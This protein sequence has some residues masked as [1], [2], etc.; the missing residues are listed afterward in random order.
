MNTDLSPHLVSAQCVLTCEELD[1]TLSFFTET[2][3]FRVDTI[4][5]ADHP[6]VAVVSGHGIRIRLERSQEPANARIRLLCRDRDALTARTGGQT[7]LT[8]PNGTRIELADAEPPVV[9]PKAEQSLVV[10]RYHDESAW[11]VGRAGMLYRD[12]IPD[13]LGGAFIASHIRIPNGGPVPDYVHFHKIHFQMIYSYRGWARL[14]YEDQGEPFLLKAGDCVLQPPQIRHR[15][16]EC[17]DGM[18]VV[19][20]GCPAEHETF[21][22]HEMTLP[23]ETLA[24]EREFGGQ[25]FVRHHAERARFTPFRIAGLEAR[26]IGIG[27]GTHGLAGVMVV[28]RAGDAIDT[29]RWEHDRE[30]LFYFVLEGSLDL[31]VG[32][33]TE[34]LASGDTF[35]LPAGA[36]CAFNACSDDMELL[37]VSLPA[38]AAAPGK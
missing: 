3:G 37:E 18:E 25:R 34:K 13:R 5:P 27:D 17:S 15:V 32:P 28:R 1:P 4:H 26:D 2:L 14:V 11:S 31:S 30:F 23:T 12:L 20:I 9:V 21:A 36:S 10:S 6:T 16:L 29:K 22:D 35:V 24:P 33:T 38:L 19:E 8:A 7:S